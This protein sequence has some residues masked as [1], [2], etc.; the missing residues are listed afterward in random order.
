MPPSALA[1]AIAQPTASSAPDFNAS[2]CDSDWLGAIRQ[3]A[4]RELRPLVSEIDR[5]GVY[6]RAWM[7]RLGTLG[8][9]AQSAPIELGGG[10][11][12]LKATL[13]GMEAVSS[14]CLSTGFC[15]WCQM[16]CGWYIQHGASEF[17]KR[18]VLPQV[19]AGTRMGATGLS[20]PMKHFAGIEKI[21]LLARREASGYRV[22]GVLPW[23]SNASGEG[24]FAF[25]ARIEDGPHAGKYLM[26]VSPGAA[27]GVSLGDGG[28]FIAL[29]GSST[30]SARF[31]DA[32]VSDD[33]VLAAPCEDY[34]ARIRPGFILGQTGFGL[35]LVSS[36]V[37]LMKKADR[38]TAHV[39]CF[40]DDR[41]E[42]IQADLEAA[43]RFTFALA[44]EIG[45]GLSPT[46]P[47]K[48]L[49]RDVIQARLTA[50]ELSLRA[51]QAAMLYAGA[52]GY[53]LGGAPE[54]KLRESYFVAVVTPAMKQLKKMLATMDGQA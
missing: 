28:H 1:E 42:H 40:L 29:E 18:E 8:G 15:V 14:E 47:R 13:Q 11:R 16:V 23:V 33:W 43:R 46:S 6:P 7:E 34:V 19:L 3:S 4:E 5:E 9:F 44:D 54:R 26:A 20:N 53:R 52:S 49:A 2:L 25:V 51:S 37:E 24:F 48:D 27:P 38:R 31:E 21:N 35:G 39:N 32:F 45:T 10:G 41:A 22:S 36:C 12:G 17:L 50:S 30:M